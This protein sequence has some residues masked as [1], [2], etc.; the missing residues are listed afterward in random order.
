MICLLYYDV[1]VRLSCVMIQEMIKQKI[2]AFVKAA[3]IPPNSGILGHLVAQVFSSFYVV[4]T[5]PPPVDPQGAA[6]PAAYISA[7]AAEQSAASHST[8]RPSRSTFHEGGEEAAKR[9]DNGGDEDGLLFGLKR[10][11][12]LLSWASFYVDKGKW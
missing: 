4:E 7:A 9:K 6:D 5:Y 11:L 2:P 8:S 12:T 3:F 10:N 1:L